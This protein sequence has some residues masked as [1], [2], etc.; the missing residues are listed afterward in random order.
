MIADLSSINKKVAEQPVPQ[1]QSSEIKT[2]SLGGGGASYLGGPASYLGGPAIAA[3]IVNKLGENFEQQLAPETPRPGVSQTLTRPAA[4]LAGPAELPA[5]RLP[6]RADGA[7]GG[8]EARG[9]GAREGT[10]AEKEEDRQEEE[11]SKRRY[12]ESRGEPRAVPRG[13]R[14]AARQRRSTVAR[15]QELP[16]RIASMGPAADQLRAQLLAD[17]SPRMSYTLQQSDNQRVIDMLSDIPRQH[18][19]SDGNGDLRQPLA[20]GAVLSR[21]GSVAC[22]CCSSSSCSSWCT[23]PRPRSRRRNRRSSSGS[24][25][26]SIWR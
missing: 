2:A 14:D 13:T 15:I 19:A 3:A 12:S 26:S 16:L 9:A 1:Q 24:S 21:P 7:Q 8:A 20:A 4:L 18:R 22:S 25:P 6:A 17:A 5:L 23:S 11:S 10:R